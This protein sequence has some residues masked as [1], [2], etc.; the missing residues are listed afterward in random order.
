[1]SKTVTSK[2][3]SS[4]SK[5]QNLDTPYHVENMEQFL[6]SEFMVRTPFLEKFA[7]DQLKY[8]C[9]TESALYINEYRLKRGV[10]KRKYHQWLDRCEYLKARH[11]MCLEIIGLR[12]EKEMKKAN[13][14]ILKLRQYQYDP[15]FAEAEERE[16]KMKKKS[17]EADSKQPIHVHLPENKRVIRVNQEENE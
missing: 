17:D 4:R 3:K 6:G 1:M 14:L 13:A 12:R 11:D 5:S 2:R 16:V 8:Y 9:E 10:N 15:G 7:D